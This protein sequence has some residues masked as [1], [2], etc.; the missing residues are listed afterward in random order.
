[1]VVQWCEGWS[2][3]RG[4]GFKSWHILKCY[5]NSVFFFSVLSVSCI[6]Y[7]KKVSYYFNCQFL[8]LSH[9]KNSCHEFVHDLEQN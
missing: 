4:S 9:N 8:Q 7:T 2:G 3:I 5:T 1:M 6:A